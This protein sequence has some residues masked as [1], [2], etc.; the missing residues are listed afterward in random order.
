MS[1][2]EN[3]TSES[4]NELEQASISSLILS[5]SSS[6]V[7]HLGLDPDSKEKKDMRIAE[8]NIEM[9]E[10]LKEKTK[11]NLK[12]TEA[13]LIDKCLQDLKMHFISANNS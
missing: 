6:A 5:I 11:G 3:K 9:L 2:N 10:V 7:I 13:N 1:E 4:I 12:D 8:F